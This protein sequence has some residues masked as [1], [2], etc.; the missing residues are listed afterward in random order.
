MTVYILNQEGNAL[1]EKGK[2]LSVG[3]THKEYVLTGD[4]ELMPITLGKYESEAKAHEVLGYIAGR[5]ISPT[6]KELETGIIYIDLNQ[7]DKHIK[8]E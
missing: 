2:I 6:S 8:V 5:I 7:I 4:D 3:G 1:I